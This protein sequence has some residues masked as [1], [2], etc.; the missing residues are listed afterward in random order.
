MPNPINEKENPY[1]S[2]FWLAS[3]CS[4]SGELSELFVKLVSIAIS[5][6]SQGASSLSSTNEEDPYGRFRWLARLSPQ[7]GELSGSIVGLMGV[8]LAILGQR[9]LRKKEQ[10]KWTMAGLGLLLAAYSADK[11]ARKLHETFDK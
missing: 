1:A 5:R 8:A 3:C 4:Q 2:S 10:S 7:S 9:Q 11:A 6:A